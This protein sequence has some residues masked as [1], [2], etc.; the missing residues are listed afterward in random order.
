VQQLHGS[1]V[2]ILP[3][4]A[5]HI[6]PD[7]HESQYPIPP[8]PLHTRSSNDIYQDHPGTPGEAFLSPVQTPQGSPSK[9]H[10][11]PGAF[12]LPNVFDHALKL[13]PTAGTP[14]KT[15][16]GGNSPTSP[17]KAG[18]AAAEDSFGDTTVLEA[19]SN[20]GSPGKRPNK[21]NTPPEP[22]PALKTE[23]TH[24]NYAAVSRQ[25]PYKVRD[26]DTGHKKYATGHGLTP[27]DLE[28]LQ[29]PSVKRLANVTQ[30]CKSFL[31][32]L[33]ALPNL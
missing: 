5:S 25:E 23:S 27:S 20:A 32:L 10:M 13:M 9:H 29:K 31:Q 18:F 1:T 22:R 26:V 24:L 21:E 4:M 7:K 16:R 17:N 12:D 14:S 8:P 2:S 30:L 11:P 28:I 6:S 3:A 33:S 19:H 15:N